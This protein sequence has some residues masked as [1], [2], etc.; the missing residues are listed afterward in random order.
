M[1]KSYTAIVVRQLETPHKIALL[2]RV[3]GRVDGIVSS[4]LVRVGSLIEYS[5]ERNRG[6]LRYIKQYS[7]IDVPLSIARADIL[8]WHHVLELCYYFVPPGSFTHQLFELL[9]FLYTVD[10]GIYWSV[11]AKKLY[12]FKLL[13]RIGVYARLPRLPI[14]QIQHLQAI[15]LNLIADEVIDEQCE[16]MLDEWLRLCVYEHPAI[17]KFRTVHF[18]LSK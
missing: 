14:E 4:P 13:V 10:I 18:L 15:P 1:Q 9:E 2:D 5:V 12:L 17:R 3:A 7:V 11:R 8:F 6:T 16:K